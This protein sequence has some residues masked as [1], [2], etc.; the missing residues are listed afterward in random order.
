[1]PGK[2]VYQRQSDE[3]TEV[4]LIDELI[5]VL[6]IVLLGEEGGST[7]EQRSTDGVR[8]RIVALDQRR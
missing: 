8:I 2:P 5:L 7:L 4:T 3:V 6:D 1:M